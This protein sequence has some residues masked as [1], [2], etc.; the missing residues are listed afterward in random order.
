MIRLFK[1]FEKTEYLH[2]VF[3]FQTNNFFHELNFININNNYSVN[4]M[5]N[6]TSLKLKV[7]FT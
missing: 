7:L 6:K 4:A 5:K 3:A 1:I 2:T